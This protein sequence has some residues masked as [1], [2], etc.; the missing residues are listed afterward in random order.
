MKIE[1][2]E[3]IDLL[4]YSVDQWLQANM[5]TGDFNLMTKTYIKN[6]NYLQWISL[7]AGCI[8]MAHAVSE[9]GGGSSY[10]PK[11]KF[12]PIKSHTTG[13]FKCSYCNKPSHKKVFAAKKSLIKNKR[14]IKRKIQKRRVTYDGN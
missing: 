11:T 1:E 4:I 14:H 10:T 13:L 5:V 7:V 9:G 2:D 3:L 12:K 6:T 8:D